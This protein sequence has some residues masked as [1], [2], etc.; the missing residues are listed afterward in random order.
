MIKLE[1]TDFQI[2][3]WKELLNIPSGSTKTYKEIA[4]AISRPK[5]FRAVANA[6]A[7][8]PYAPEAV[9]YTHLTLPT[10]YSV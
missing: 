9:S 4:I 1:G 10:I 7:Q 6:C 3:V 2:A 5:S 8:N